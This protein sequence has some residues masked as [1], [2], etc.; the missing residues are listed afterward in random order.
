MSF[1]SLGLGL[2]I[3]CRIQNLEKLSK[4]RHLLWDMYCSELDSYMGTGTAFG[5]GL[6]R[7]LYFLACCYVEDSDFGKPGDA[8]GSPGIVIG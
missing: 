8:C 5:S 6:Q 3:D 7:K 1:L 4:I 2:K